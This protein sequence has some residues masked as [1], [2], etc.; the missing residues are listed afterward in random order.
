MQKIYHKSI[1]GIAVMFFFSSYGQTKDGL[2]TDPQ[3]REVQTFQKKIQDYTQKQ[4]SEIQRLKGLG[5]KEF[6]SEKGNE[7]QL[8]GADENGRP[9]YYTTLN[10]GAAKMTKADNLYPGGGIG[11]NITGNNMVIGQWDYSKPRITHQLLT[12]KINTYDS[13]QNQTISRHSTNIAGTLAGNNGEAEARGIAY[14]AK[15]NAYDWV[16][17]VQEMLSEAYNGTTGILVANNSYG[18]DPMYLQTYQFGKYNLTAQSWDN[19]MYLKPYLQIVKA[20]GNAREIDPGIVPQVSAKNGYDLLEGAGVAKNVLV[21]ASAKKNINMSSDEAFDISAFSS[22]GPTDDGRI[23]P[24]ICAPGENIYS[25][26]E[27]YD[28]AYG[29]YRGTSS[30]AAVVSG[31]ITLLQQYYKSVNPSQ[32]YMLSSTVRAL[33]AHTAND[34]GTEGPDYIYGWGLADAKRASEAIYN[35]IEGIINNEKKSTLIKEVTLNQGNKY[36]LYVVPYETTQPL[37]ATISW[38]DPQGNTVSNVVDLS[39][40]NV[41]NDLDL[42][43]VKINPDGTE[44]TYYPW[45]LGGMSNLTGAATNTSTND[46]DTIERVDIKNPQKVT[47]KIIVSPKTNTTP[48]LP[49]GNQ[50]FSIVVSNVDFCYKEDLKTLVS[51]TDDITTTQTIL[52]K[53]I[54]ASNKIIAPVQGVEYIASRDILLLPGFQVEQGSGFTAFITPCFDI[55]SA[56]RYVAQQRVDA[57]TLSTTTSGVAPEHFT[58]FPNP[59]KEEVNIRFF[60]QSESAIKISV[61]DASGKLVST[62]QSSTKFPK[63]EFIKTIDTRS[64]SQGIYMVSIETAEYKET[65]KLIIK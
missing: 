57:G 45:K 18:F 1:L 7:K 21:V 39:S 14:E 46:V 20:A 51:P 15:I 17:D 37:S 12:G 52:A 58:L 55:I 33:L 8:I 50:T 48:L 43:I 47:Y 9:M 28:A 64:F 36:T 25:S 3:E 30:A 24:D 11:L 32:K 31:I 56:L 61:Y 10:A 41:I 19:L 27:T 34:K 59:A 49:S 53:Q 44:S 29:T 60:L 2:K 42:K 23:K 22:Y 65:K 26:I 4:K 5:H 6:I 38:T 62:D 54:V 63:G 40:P 16:N 35:N 13:S